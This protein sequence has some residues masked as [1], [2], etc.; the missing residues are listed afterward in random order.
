MKDVSKPKTVTEVRK[1]SFLNFVKNTSGTPKPEALKFL[2]SYDKSVDISTHSVYNPETRTTSHVICEDHWKE[3]NKCQYCRDGQYVKSVK[4]LISFVVSLVGKEWTSTD[5]VSGETKKG[6]YN[7][8]KILMLPLGRSKANVA[9]MEGISREKAFN[10][11]MW[12]VSKTERVISN[13]KVFVF[14]PPTILYEDMY[15][16]KLG[17][18]LPDYTF[19]EFAKKIVEMNGDDIFTTIISSFDN[20]K[21]LLDSL[22]S[23]KKSETTEDFESEDYDAHDID[24]L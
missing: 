6:L 21:E 11:R 9:A 8:V 13:K 2:H 1:I 12:L 19:S 22:S 5:P 3:L 10:D 18:N 16:S 14:E 15:K 17:S 4:C 7:P 23:T 24:V 20:G